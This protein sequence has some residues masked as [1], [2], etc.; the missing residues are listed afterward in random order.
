MNTIELSVDK[1]FVEKKFADLFR[2]LGRFENKYKIL[3]KENAIPR[4]HSARRVPYAI[5]DKLKEKLKELEENRIIAKSDEYDEW[6]H[7]LVFRVKK[8]KSLRICLDPAEL[9]KWILDESFLVPTFE[10]LVIYL[11]GVKYFSVLDLKDGFWQIELD[12]ESQKLCTF[13]TPFGNYKF[14]RMPFGI[15]SGPKVFQKMNHANFGDIERVFTY[16]D[17]VLVTGKTKQEHDETLMNVLKRAR[18][19]NVKFNANKLKIGVNKVK[20]LGHVFSE[21]KIE[22]DEDR[23]EAIK[24]MGEPKT[25]KDLQKFLGVINYVRSFIPNLSELTAPLRE[26]LKKNVIYNWQPRHTEAFNEIKNKIVNSPILVPFDTTKNIEIQCDAS[27]SG[28][29]C[30]LLQDGKPISFA[31]RRLSEAEQNYSQIEKEFLSILFACKKFWFYAYGRTVLVVNDHKPLTSIIKKEIHKIPSPK[32]QL[33]RMKLLKFDIQLKHAPGKTIHIADY[34]SR[35]SMETEIEEDEKDLADAVLSINASDEKTEEFRKET[36]LD[37]TLRDLK[38]Y[39]R[40]GWPNNKSKCSENTKFFYKMRNEIYLVDDI[41][42]VDERIL[43]PITMRET[44]LKQL[45]EAHFGVSKTKKRAKGTVYWP[46]I[47]NDIEKM[48]SAC[49]TCQINSSKNQKEPLIPHEIPDRPFEKLACDIFEFSAKDYLVIVDYFSK[50]IELKQLNGKRAKDVNSTL[51]EVFSRNGIPR[52]IVADNMPFNSYECGEFAKSLDFKF[53]TSSPRY[54]RSNG[55]AE[56]GVQ[57]CKNIMR[58]A[59]NLDEIYLALLEYR[60]TPTK[61]LSHSPSQL[62][63]NRILRTKIPTRLEN[64]EPKNNTNAQI[65]LKNKQQ[66]T[67]RFHDR[68]AKS[69]NDFNLNDKVLVWVGKWKIGIIIKIWHTPRSYVVKTDDGEYRRN[70]NHIREYIESENKT[71]SPAHNP[72]EHNIVRTTRSGKEY[73]NENKQH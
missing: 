23:I 72:S 62:I 24:Q 53:E 22:P 11:K 34:L 57:I 56:R 12:E 8:D 19:K 29:G 28:L 1:D 47:D 67:K 14:L 55:L 4:A 54:P 69:R 44:I 30:C 61:D 38:E 7:N 21:D 35:Y 70:S 2:G 60:S 42:F 16:M 65:E 39:C 73:F 43:V 52:I 66:N 40:S 31:S 71:Q 37:P 50:W 25:K 36:E 45:H 46:G 27:K 32:L 13:A 59:K 15:K 26:L 58:K 64:F 9:N 5:R 51:L 10:E 48:I 33:I 49:H 63:Q 17:D 6:A 41:L 3:L 20:Y 18:E 68:T